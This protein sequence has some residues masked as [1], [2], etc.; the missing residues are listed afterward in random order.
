MRETLDIHMDSMAA[1]M[2][3]FPQEEFGQFSTGLNVFGCGGLIIGNFLIGVLMD[4][5]RNDYRIP[6]FGQRCSPAS[7]SSRCCSSFVDGNCMA[8]QI[9]MSHPSQ[10]VRFDSAQN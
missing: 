1:A 6:F 2:L 9:I 3:L 8:D 4:T 5:G 10:I 7:R